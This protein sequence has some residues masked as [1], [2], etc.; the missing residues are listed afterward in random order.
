MTT[1]SARAGSLQQPVEQRRLAGAEKPGQHGQ[2]DRRS[3]PLRSHGGV[4]KRWRRRRPAAR[5]GRSARTL[6]RI[7]ASTRAPPRSCSA[8]KRLAEDERRREGRDDRLGAEDDARDDRRDAREAEELQHEADDIAADRQRHRERRERRAPT[9]AR[10]SR[11]RGRSARSAAAE[12]DGSRTTFATTPV[13][14]R[15]AP[16][17][18]NCTAVAALAASASARPRQSSA[19]ADGPTTRTTPQSASAT[20]ATSAAGRPRAVDER[21]REHDQDRVG[22]EDDDGDGDRDE[23]DRGE[24]EDAD[25][26]RGEAERSRR[27]RGL[28]AAPR[29]S[30]RD[31]SAAAPMSAS[32]SKPR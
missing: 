23:G 13:R 32:I 4:L 27:R 16:T 5:G 10:D 14:L 30:V 28:P 18:K 17:A 11:K 24:I 31:T 12:A 25:A 26:G 22:V 20:T 19:P 15:T 29:G 7:A 6:A 2:R 9:A 3:G 21:A 8:G 1:V